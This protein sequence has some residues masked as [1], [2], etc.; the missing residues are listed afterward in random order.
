MFFVFQVPGPNQ[1]LEHQTFVIREEDH[2]F[3]NAIKHVLLEE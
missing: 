3:G 2:T 1:T